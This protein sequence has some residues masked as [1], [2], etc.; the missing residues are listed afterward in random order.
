MTSSKGFMRVT[1]YF[2][3]V[4]AR[5]AWNCASKIYWRHLRHSYTLY[6]ASAPS[7]SPTS[8]YHI[9]M[10][11]L[12]LCNCSCL[13]HFSTCQ[14]IRWILP[15]FFYFQEVSQRNASCAINIKFSKPMLVWCFRLSVLQS[16]AWTCLVN[17]EWIWS[18]N[19]AVTNFACTQVL[20]ST[21]TGAIQR[22]FL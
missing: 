3:L 2:R 13:S 11:F 5:Q 10:Y 14:F 8:V 21:S 18:N 17:A 15:R 20:T 19:S 6:I 16:M 7:S 22:E 1:G 9:Q 4:I 12:S